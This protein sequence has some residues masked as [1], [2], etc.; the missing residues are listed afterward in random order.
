[1]ANKHFIMMI[2]LSSI[3][4]SLATKDIVA[5]L[6]NLEEDLFLSDHEQF[7]CF[8][9]VELLTKLSGKEFNYRNVDVELSHQLLND[10]AKELRLKG[11]KDLENTMEKCLLLDKYESPSDDKVLM[12]Y[13]DKLNSLESSLDVS[14]RLDAIDAKLTSKLSTIDKKVETVLQEL[15]DL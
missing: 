2:L 5:E 13:E 8:H 1:M 11:K 9:Y 7:S 15:Q 6:E 3:S 10:A 12:S 4:A 14:Q